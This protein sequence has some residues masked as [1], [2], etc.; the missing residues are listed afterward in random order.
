MTAEGS[1]IDINLVSSLS[2]AGKE[3]EGGEHEP[4]TNIVVTTFATALEVRFD[5][6]TALVALGCSGHP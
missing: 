4:V 3:L 1:R 2:L 5:P 6:A